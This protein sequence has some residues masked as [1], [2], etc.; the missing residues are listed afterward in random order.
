M[1]ITTPKLLSW[2]HRLWIPFVASAVFLALSNTALAQSTFLFRQ[3]ASDYIIIGPTTEGNAYSDYPF[4]SP[5]G[6]LQQFYPSTAFSSS[7]TPAIEILSIAFRVNGQG[8]ASLSEAFNRLTVTLSTTTRSMDQMTTSYSQNAGADAVVVFDGPIVFNA[9]KS[10]GPAPFDIRIPLQKG[11]I[12]DRTHGNLILDISQDRQTG[13]LG[14]LDAQT[15]PYFLLYGT[16]SVD[17]GGPLGELIPTEF[18]YTLVPEP[19]PAALFT[20]GLL[21][22]AAIFP[23]KK[24][25]KGCS[26][27]DTLSISSV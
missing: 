19:P 21:F 9:P 7:V 27:R 16:T 1:K 17:R 5:N 23:R 8:G 3:S 15:G 4:R 24:Q 12:Y 26:S 2:R 18:G 6:R 10:S 11:F 20:P 25:T 14:E 13:G 22:L